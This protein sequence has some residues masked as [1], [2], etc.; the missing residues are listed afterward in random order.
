MSSVDRQVRAFYED[1]GLPAAR[2][3][4][5]LE[6]AR[7]AKAHRRRRLVV[8]VA[9]ALLLFAAAAVLRTASQARA[10]GDRVAAEVAM[11]H[12]KD[13][14]VEIAAATYPELGTAL[15][16]LNFALAAPS[17]KLAD[18]RLLGGR[19]C[20]IQAQL[21]AQLKVRD[22]AGQTATLYVTEL[23]P[24]LEGLPGTRRQLDGISIEV[25]SEDGLLYALAT[26]R[27][28]V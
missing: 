13:L 5:I 8:A 4:E 7:R 2:A 6:R 1:Q 26:G 11:N 10:L 20:S 15:D 25:W 18:H 23:T 14:D 24:P 21:A 3:Q 27:P 22:G 16:K 19:Y 17:T 12:K 9:A 28:T